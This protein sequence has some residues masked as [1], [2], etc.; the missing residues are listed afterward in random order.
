[1]RL[2]FDAIIFKHAFEIGAARETAAVNCSEVPQRSPDFAPERP[3]NRPGGLLSSRAR[4]VCAEL[5]LGA[6]PTYSAG[7]EHG[8]R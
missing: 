6:L 1:M 4:P 8:C 7:G 5:S 2:E 3:A